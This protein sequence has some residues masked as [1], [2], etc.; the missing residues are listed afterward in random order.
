MDSGSD[1][2]GFGAAGSD[3]ANP[4]VAAEDAR[5]DVDRIIAAATEAD[6][7]APL[8]ADILRARAAENSGLED[9]IAKVDGDVAGYAAV[10]HFRDGYPAMGE[11]VVDPKHRNVGMGGS[12]VA[13]IL[14]TGGS[15]ARVWAHG[16]LPAARAVAGRLD[17]VALRELLQ[18]RRPLDDTLSPPVLPDDVLIR[19]YTPAD[20]AELL[21]VNNAAFS[22]HPEQGGWTDAQLDERAAEQWFDPSGIFL[23]VDADRP[24]HVLG[25]HWTKLHADQPGLG[26]VYVVAVDPDA[27]GRNLGQILTTVGMR[28]LRERGADTVML[29]VEADNERA[30]RVYEKVGFRRF[31]ADVAYGRR[32]P[33]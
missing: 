4:L 14:G 2:H 9:V 12:L 6:G 10:L 19:T 1:V 13:W 24:D 15:D 32:T 11:A 22:W 16:D 18:L 25:F 28:Y 17:L 31:H 33:G 7:T 21:R 26:E 20:R 8:S 23:A 30:V 27:R 5:A 29:Y 3:A